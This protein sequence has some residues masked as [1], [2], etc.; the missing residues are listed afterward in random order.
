[1]KVSV[2]TLHAVC[3]YGTQ[4]QAYAT[5]EKLKD[6]FED[7]EFINYKRNDTYG[8][9][10][11]DS[12][13]KGNIFKAL[14]IFPTIMRWKSVFGKFQKNNL[15]LSKKIYLKSEDFS[16]FICD[17]DAYI[18][19]SDQVWNS[20]WNN[21]IIGEMYLNFVPK[22]KLKFAFSSSF[23][24]SKLTKEEIDKT[25]NFINQYK[26]ISVR[27][28]SGLEIL[29][30][31]YKYYN[32]IRLVDP[33]LAVD[34]QFWRNF[35]KKS[36]KVIKEK[37]ILI[38]NLN[39]SK[40]FDEF[41]KEISRKTGLKLYR[42]C[43]RYDQIFRNGKSLVI[44]KIEDFI[45]LVD[46]AEYVLT[47]SFHAAAFSMNLNTMPICVYPKNYSSRISDF[48]K[49]VDSEQVHVKAYN[50]FDVINRKVDFEKVNLILKREREK[51]EKFLLEVKNII[52]EE[53][54]V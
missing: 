38:Y 13:A 32:A 8:K 21:G 4:L 43:T 16:N 29:T 11:I 52:E 18:S 1:M 22:N 48:L 28:E 53:K 47:D 34:D 33:T 41:A 42:F 30:N 3:N 17:S 12:F 24:K 25:K 31:Q 36:K 51:V 19:G 15:N 40:D 44:P 27:E 49:L 10:L 2:L 23:G 37:Y 9:G 45:N 39:R 7:V 5:Q 26:M 35:G 6:F 50:D 14:A 54:S 46:N 20:G